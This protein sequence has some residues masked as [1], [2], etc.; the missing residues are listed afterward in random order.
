MFMGLI[1]E[2]MGRMF[3]DSGNNPQY[4]IRKIIKNSKQRY[5]KNIPLI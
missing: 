5:D 3:L 2:Y 4:V 1:G